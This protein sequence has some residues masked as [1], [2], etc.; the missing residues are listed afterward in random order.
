MKNYLFKIVSFLLFTG[1]FLYF[2]YKCPFDFIFGISCPGCGMTRALISALHFDFSMAFYYHPLFPLGILLFIFFILDY[3]NIYQM[4]YKTKN[5]LLLL[6]AVIF[7]ITYIIRIITK[8][9]VLKF[10]FTQSAVYKF[11]SLFF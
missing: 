11:F 1:I 10:D 4:K 7:I 5:V 6:I 3:F 2:L 8:S 9:P